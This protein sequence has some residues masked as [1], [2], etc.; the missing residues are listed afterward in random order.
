MTLECDEIP[1]GFLA[2]ISYSERKLSIQKK[3]DE[4]LKTDLKT[5]LKIDKIDL[6][7]IELITKNPMISISEI[8]K[9]IKRTV[10]PTKNRM[11]KLKKLNII[12]REGADKGGY[13]KI[14]ISNF[15]L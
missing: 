3:A 5:D 8:A 9:K 2:T 13:W 11:V 4:N 1:N 7:I 12:Q 6:D 14:I 10:T 15:P